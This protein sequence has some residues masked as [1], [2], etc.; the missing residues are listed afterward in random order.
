MKCSIDSCDRIA[1]KIHLCL[2]HYQRFS[3]NG[4]AFDQSPIVDVSCMKSKFK[5]KIGIEKDNGCM[6]WLGWK[7]K[8]GYG[9]FSIANKYTFAHRYSYEFHIGKIPDGLCVCHKCDN[10]SCVNPKHLFLGT[11]FDNM[12]DMK[13]KNRQPYKKG[14]PL[15][16][17]NKG[18]KHV[19]AKLDEDKVRDIKIKLADGVK[20]SIL[21]QLYNVV[22]QT[23]YEIKNGRNWKHVI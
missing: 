21:A 14:A 1:K 4:S 16:I 22:D 8:D 10:P 5:S 15:N 18:S 20:G 2:A 17:N 19:F 7:N 6:N 23:I 11:H 9:K 3:R 12:Q 13:K